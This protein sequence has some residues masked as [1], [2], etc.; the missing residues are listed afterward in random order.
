MNYCD[1]KGMTQL[2]E[3]METFTFFDENE[4]HINCNERYVNGYDSLGNHYDWIVTWKMQ[5]LL[6]DTSCISHNH[7]SILLD[8]NFSYTTYL[9][10]N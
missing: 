2:A 1:A 9:D 10:D 8:H 4:R 7:R 3:C 5:K 6:I